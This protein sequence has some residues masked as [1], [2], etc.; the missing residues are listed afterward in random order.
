MVILL[1]RAKDGLARLESSLNPT[2]L[3]GWIA[4]VRQTEVKVAMPKFKMSSTTTLSETLQSLGMKDAFDVKLADFSGMDG[5][6]HWLCL[7]AVLQR[8][9]IEVNEEGTEAAAATAVAMFLGHQPMAE[10]PEF[11][12][13]HAFLFL[14]RDSTTG[15][16][17]FTGRVSEPEN[18]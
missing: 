3:A 10:P 9:F 15:S 12:A 8:A 14:I 17:L 13:D 2:S 5:K 16:I 6:V 18:G 7:S 1:P 11:R 4:Q